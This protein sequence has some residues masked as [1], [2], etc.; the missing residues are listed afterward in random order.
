MK[1][2]YIISALALGLTLG[3]VSPNLA[4]AQEYITTQS[5]ELDLAITN[6]RVAQEV[7]N[8]TNT[9]RA[10]QLSNYIERVLQAADTNSNANPDELIKVLD[11]ATTSTYLL[12]GKNA[13]PKTSKTTDVQPAPAKTIAESQVATVAEPVTVAEEV[14]SAVTPEAEEVATKGTSKTQSA[15]STSTTIK[16]E[17]PA[18]PE[19]KTA[20]ANSETD[21]KAILAT[22]QINAEHTTVDD[23]TAPEV[24][25]TG[26]VKNNLVGR[27]IAISVAAVVAMA[28]AIVI[29]KRIKKN[30]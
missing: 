2:T 23:T 26:E 25:H 7:A 5:T 22:A 15:E 6:A 12:L 18:Q 17:V 8:Q 28:G 29:V 13:T 21:H 24:P 27:I 10:K 11:D 16:L 9:L 20:V 30:A 19:V 3:V 1:N 14:S 4:Y